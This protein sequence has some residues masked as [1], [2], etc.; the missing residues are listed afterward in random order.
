MASKV[1]TKFV[2]IAGIIIVAVVGGVAAIGL[3]MMNS[4][5]DQN[6]TRGDDALKAGDIKKAVQEYGR[7]V[8]K[9]RGNADW[10]RKWLGAIE[11]STPNSRQAYNDSYNG[12]YLTALRALCDADRNNLEPFR[13]YFEERYQ[14][15]LRGGASLGAWESLETQYRDI[16]EKNFR[17]DQKGKDILRRYRGLA[18]AGMIS[19]NSELDQAKIDQALLDLNTAYAAD[20]N[21]SDSVISAV[22]LMRTTAERLAKVGKQVEADKLEADG[23]EKLV[24]FLKQHPESQR[25]R[26]SLLT[27]EMTE[28]VRLKRVTGTVLDVLKA[29]K[30]SIA[31]VVNSINQA[32]PADADPIVALAVSPWAGVVL[33]EGRTVS[34]EMLDHVQKG[35]SD[36]PM[37][38]LGAA[39]LAMQ[40]QELDRCIELAKTVAALPDR[41]VSLNGALLFQYR[42]EAVRVQVDASFINWELEKDPAKKDELVKQIRVLRDDLK[43]RIGESD[44]RVL[45]VDGRLDLISGDFAGAR[46]RISLYN[47]QTQ[48]TDPLML[49]IEADL[50]MK[51]GQKGAAKAVYERILSLDRQNLRA[52]RALG[53]IEADM[54][55]YKSAYQ[56]LSLALAMLP[57][58]PELKEMVTNAEMLATENYDKDPVL[59]CLKAAIKAGSGLTGDQ[60]AAIRIL[61]DC[62]KDH[63]GDVRLS[64]QISQHL[65]ANKDTE[66]AL[67]AL[68]AGIAVNPANTAIKTMRKQMEKD[69]L[70][71]ILQQ[72]NDSNANETQKNLARWAVYMRAGK[73]EEAKEPLALAV[74]KD[75]D[76]PQVIDSQFEDAMFRKDQATLDVIVAKAQ[77][78]NLDKVGGLLYRARS[79]ALSGKSQEAIGILREVTSKDKLNLLAWRLLGIALYD[80]QRP[81]EAVDALQRALD[82]KP[83]DIISIDAYILAKMGSDQAGDALIFARKNRDVASGDGQFAEMLMTL[84]ANAPGGD[85]SWAIEART[86]IAERAPGNRP[87]RTKLAALLVN[88]NRKDEAAPL[89]AALRKEEPEDQIGVQLEASF[90]ARNGD[91]PGAV[92]LMQDFIAGLPKEKRNDELY[93]N[94]ARLLQQIGANAEARKMLEDGRAYQDPK[95]TLVDRELGDMLFNQNQW[96]DANV[97]Y[98]RVVDAGGDED[99]TPGASRFA[100]R[101]RILEGHLK[102]K[103]FAEVI[104]LA[105]KLPAVA[106]GDPTVL[107]LEA[108]AAVGMNDNALALKLYGQAVA[109]DPKSP[110]GYIKRGDWEMSDPARLKDAESD[111]DQA[112]RV[113]PSSAIARIRL[114][115]L[116]R[117]S[118]RD[119]LALTKLRETIGIETSNQQFRLALVNMCTELG[120]PRDAAQACDDAVKQFGG[121]SAPIG[122]RMRASQCWSHVPDWGKTVDYIASVWS[123]RKTPEIA[124]A[125]IEALLNNNDVRQAYNVFQLPEVKLDQSL[126]LRMLH[127]RVQAKQG[128]TAQ[129]AEEINKSLPTVNQDSLEES[130]LFMSGI[131]GIYPKL[132][133]QLAVLGRIEAGHPFT[134]YLGIKV[135]E[136]RAKDDALKPAAYAALEALANNSKDDKVR[137]S[138]WSLLGNYSY[139]A[140]NWEEA[141]VRFAKGIELDKDNIE[142]NNNLAYVLANKLDKG[143]EALPFAE[144]AARGAPLNSGFLDTLGSCQLAVKDYPK[145]AVTLRN[146]LNSAVNDVERTPVYI[147]L[148]WLRLKQ[149]DK[150]EAKRL[151]TQAHDLMLSTPT[152]RDAFQADL[153]VLDKAIDGR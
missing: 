83:D 139:V 135:N 11:K 29:S 148:G 112:I 147:H 33:P 142:L 9:D 118:G 46:T 99:E 61:R 105:G 119:E 121:A 31:A 27:E 48:R 82:I 6:I 18:R 80:T 38:L 26:F 81:A 88:T 77:S 17:G 39:R 145:A 47:D 130:S 141:R 16:A 64:M 52:L 98:Q 133:D 129:A 117:Q 44:P 25:V 76:L 60:P 144:K 140:G 93:I 146:A 8:N 128:L 53:V 23:H 89:I 87:N 45:S 86:K 95:K 138:C 97:A 114:V 90:M 59:K 137:A 100:V 49:S 20:P 2:I 101:K 35:H 13:R 56:H 153:Q 54:S 65:F 55:D 42:P 41:P 113:D 102:L 32:S 79:L 28:A 127:A 94:S 124:V 115:G 75:P 116:Y 123:E 51:L 19:F 5:G 30:D 103:D 107:L 73:P 58:N 72:I 43:A 111:F 151:S 22:S 136:M 57:D 40:T 150:I 109:A 63:P 24:A 104:K 106:Q 149:G 69:P 152:A 12:E 37:F 1:N 36:D 74:K 132:S 62:L 15:I 66:G 67:A 143:A 92:K 131:A 134:G 120:R 84:E 4:G 108:E 14:A 34:R 78:S 85:K 70:T 21:D 126:A 7:A 50:L 125:L 3:K 96:V 68:D 122:W 10:I 91:T 71:T 110:I